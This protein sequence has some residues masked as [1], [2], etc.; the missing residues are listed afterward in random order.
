MYGYIFTLKNRI[1][2]YNLNVKFCLLPR[3]SC[4]HGVSCILWLAF[5][6]MRI[7]LTSPAISP[8]FLCHRIG[9]VDVCVCVCMFVH[10]ST[11]PRL[12]KRVEQYLFW[13]SLEIEYLN[14]NINSPSG[15]SYI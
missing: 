15:K 11:V 4:L 2:E 13:S 14:K 5:K 6:H 10:H 8:L 12:T 7:A 3:F 1:S 9:A